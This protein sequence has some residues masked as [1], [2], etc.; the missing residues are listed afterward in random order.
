[1]VA[2]ASKSVGEQLISNK[3]I[4]MFMFFPY[5][6]TNGF[7]AIPYLSTLCNVMIGIEFFVFFSMV[8]LEH[9]LSKFAFLIVVFKLWNYAIAPLFSHNAPP[10]IFYLAGTLGLIAFFEIGFSYSPIRFMS[11]VSSLFAFMIMANCIS[12]I[13]VPGGWL[14]EDGFRYY[15][16]GLRTGFPLFVIP[17]IM[18]SIIYDSMRHHKTFSTRT[19]VC[20]IFGLASLLIQWVATGIIECVVI[21]LLYIYITSTHSLSKISIKLC[22]LFVFLTNYILIVLGS[23]SRLL[24]ILLA[25]LNREITFTGRTFIWE[26]VIIKLSESPIGGFGSQSTVKFNLI[27]KSAHNQWLHIAMESGYIGLILFLFALLTSCWYLHKYKGTTIYNICAIFIIAVLVATI[28][29]IQTYVP[30][31]YIVFEMP[32]LIKKIYPLDQYTLP[33]FIKH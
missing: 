17:G 12:M 10:S 14:G 1:M 23:S 16:F 13:L 7:D 4:I 22:T 5:F 25:W 8:L 19:I 18:L 2:I 29:E 6:K 30:F 31:I 26:S 24:A 9:K 15:L 33:L 32:Y 28:T 21:A 27:E 11:A 3:Y 20:I